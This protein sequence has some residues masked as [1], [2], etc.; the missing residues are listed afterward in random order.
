MLSL[1]AAWA[2]AAPLA[3]D[4]P[5]QPLSTSIQ[6][7]SRQSG[8]SIGGNAALLEGKAAPA[9]HGTLEPA[10][11]LRKLLQGS[12][13]R[14]DLDGNK[15]VI[16]KAASVLKE[17]VVSSDA[18]AILKE[19]SA[20]AGYKAETAMSIGP[21]GGRKLLDT[22]YS[23]TVVGEDLIR[24]SV[25]NSTD[26]LFRINPTIQLLQPFDIN[27]LTRVMMRGFLIQS[28]MVDG[29][30]GNKSGQGLFIENVDRMEV[31][32]GLSGF[33]YGIG[34]IGGTLNYLTKR[35]TETAK[36]DVTI[37]NYGGSQY[38]AHVDLGGPIDAD[39]KFAYRFNLLSQDGDTVIRDQSLKRSM[40]SGALDWHA[41]D[42][43][44][45]GIDALV[46][47]Y[48][49]NG[50]PSLW[51]SPNNMND[52][53]TERYGARV[54]W[55]ISDRL[56]IRAGYG[57]QKDERDTI[58]SNLTVTSDT[59]YS[60]GKSFVSSSR[61]NTESAYA[62]IDTKFKTF[63]IANKLTLG[64]NGYAADGYGGYTAAGALPAQIGNAY[65]NLS[66][67][68][69]DSANV[70]LPAFDFGSLRMLKT[71]RTKSRNV[72]IGN[73][74]VFNGQ[75]SLLLGLNWAQYRAESYDAP[76]GTV[77]SKYDKSKAT[78]TASLLFKPLP[79]LTTYLTYIEALQPGQIVSGATF[80]NNGEIMPPAVSKQY[81]AGV[82]AELGGSLLTASLFQIE[83]ANAYSRD[84]GNGTFTMFQNGRQRHQ[85]LEL[86]LSGKATRDLTLLGG[87]TL[88]D[89]EVKKSTNNVGL[90]KVPQGVAEV[91]AKLYGEYNLP[92]LHGLTV[93]SGLYYTGKSYIDA[94][95][96][97][98]APSYT[99]VDLGL[100]YAT[101]MFGRDTIVRALVSNLTDK[102]Y[103][104][105]N[106]TIG[107][108][109]GAP[110][111]VSFSASMAL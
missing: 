10:D 66:L 52:I 104:M 93:T 9:V 67:S 36:R 103:W 21:W 101:R 49:L 31:M 13:L 7:L 63:D 32:T 15:A 107:T 12:G 22:P 73:E 26:Q 80:T 110:R 61:T 19:G 45:F 14:A 1:V 95:N 72:I 37:G 70:A 30:Q 43:L 24:N 106:Y 97:Q 111:A 4:L 85:G 35:P 90:G 62:Y 47:S 60:L 102:R 79:S 99:T 42:R 50:R 65:P 25:A 58:V 11:A 53:D 23:M 69:P 64:I 86:T 39:G 28:A 105:S 77:T 100:R 59:S 8:L 75:W 88:M 29:M 94:A 41:T 33:M 16:R 44:L 3:I 6:Q 87:L 91:M 5:A 89:A 55:D 2:Q 40:I 81:E 38:F 74:S 84:N 20:E 46:G 82:K 54:Q 76:T 18:V 71:D 83:K 78:P 34:N 48:K 96:T 109:M 68:H 27:G 98:A 51:G 108:T 56:A 57:F 17:V 92:F